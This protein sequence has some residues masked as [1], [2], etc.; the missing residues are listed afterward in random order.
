MRKQLGAIA[1][2]KAARRAIQRAR[3]DATAIATPK[4]LDNRSPAILR[5]TDGLWRVWAPPVTGPP[6]KPAEFLSGPYDER[7]EAQA[8]MDEA[9][10]GLK[11]R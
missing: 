7:D 5:G 2:Y 1:T 9:W 11:V 6:F 8:W 10:P 3:R 4:H